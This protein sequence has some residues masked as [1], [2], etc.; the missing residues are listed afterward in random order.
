MVEYVS[1]QGQSGFNYQFEILAPN[2]AISKI[3]GLYIFAQSGPQGWRAI[4]IG[5]AG[6]LND[7]LTNAH[8]KMPCI[9]ENGATHLHLAVAPDDEEVRKQQET[10]LIARW[11]P[12]CN[13]Q[14]LLRPGPAGQ[15]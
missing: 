9:K 11:Q 10:D 12:V 13:E 6:D 2:G 7:R 8:E 4:Y 5:Q 15:Q 3:A 14:G 1:W